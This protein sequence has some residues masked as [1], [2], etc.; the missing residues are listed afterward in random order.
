MISYD[1]GRTCLVCGARISDNNPDGIGCECRYAYRKAKTI[2]FFED[3]DRRNKYY[4]IKTDEIMR[5][6]IYHYK[7]VKFRSEFKKEFYPSAGAR[8]FR[9]P[10]YLGT[11]GFSPF[12]KCSHRRRR[13]T[14]NGYLRMKHS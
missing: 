6:F 5:L 4:K 9:N 14:G 7:D 10:G 1:D 3:Y 11:L 12:S 8:D 2:L 13:S